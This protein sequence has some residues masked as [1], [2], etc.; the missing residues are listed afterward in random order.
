MSFRTDMA[1]A[2][3]ELSLYI[4]SRPIPSFGTPNGDWAT[5]WTLFAG[6]IR[7]R[8]RESE[9]AVPVSIE[10]RSI[11]FVEGHNST[12]RAL[13]DCLSLS[14]A[15]LVASQNHGNA[16]VVLGVLCLVE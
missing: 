6:Q 16:V 2:T 11:P 9:S 10:W 14:L 15:L 3:V 5:R 12:P 4:Q 7:R 13:Q 8:S 1:R